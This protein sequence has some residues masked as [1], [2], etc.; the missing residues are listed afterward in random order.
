MKILFLGDYSNLHGCLRA[1]LLRRGHEVTL[2][3]DGGAYMHTDRDITLR[4]APGA[5]GSL[6][7]LA[8]VVAELPRWRGY[9]VVQLCSPIFLHLRPGKVRAVFDYLRRYNRAVCL[10]SMSLDSALV[11]N[12]DGG[13]M[14]RYSEWR[15][16]SRPA[17]LQ[18]AKPGLLGEWTNAM[19]TAHCD[20]V[21][22]AVSAVMTVLY[23]YHM[24]ALSICPAKSFYT[25]VPVDF[26]RLPALAAAPRRRGPLRI[27]AGR[28][29]DY[30]LYKGTD[31]LLQAARIVASERPADCEV[32]VAENLPLAD[33][34][35]LL[36][37]SDI[38]L[39]QIYSYTP[40]TNALQAMA[41]GKVVVSGGE[42]EYYDFIG[43]PSL[44]P[45][46]NVE[47]RL[48][49][50]VDKLRELVSHRDMVERLSAQG[51]GFVRKHND[52]ALVAD[53][54]T[55]AWQRVLTTST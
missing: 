31:L 36:A 55:A 16:G 13:R 1:E 10:T 21:Y 34:L 4:R 53:R 12:L 6:A 24:N 38:V 9:D 50:I 5:P 17:P 32:I 25:G 14:F 18:L 2:V 43:E 29:T 46:V 48:D 15:I 30:I 3:S 11:A 47:P 23:E 28:K 49:D 33:Y 54:F 19:M 35:R 27:F 8:R 45:V 41:M 52:V 40:A 39:D 7:Y 44:R 26:S 51:P 42:P 22:S 20:H 37:G